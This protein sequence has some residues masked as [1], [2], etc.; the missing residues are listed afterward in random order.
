MR[1]AKEHSLRLARMMGSGRDRLV[2]QALFAGG[3]RIQVEAQVSITRGAVSGKNHVPSRPGEPPNA[4][5]HRLSDNI[6]TLQPAP[7]RVEVSSNAPYAVALEYGTS[8]MAE[9]PYMRPATQKK[10]GEV[11]DLVRRAVNAVI[12]GG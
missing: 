7:L 5:T 1:G 3:E 11:V 9:R 2:G 6:E 4:D 10:R 12:R 8:K